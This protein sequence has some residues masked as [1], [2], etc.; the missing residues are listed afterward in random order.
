MPAVTRRATS[1]CPR[2]RF[3]ISL[4]SR[5]CVRP[6]SAMN[7]L[8]S[9]TILDDSNGL[10][11]NCTMPCPT[12]LAPMRTMLWLKPVTCMAALTTLNPRPDALMPCRSQDR[13][14]SPATCWPRAPVALSFD[15]SRSCFRNSGPRVSRTALANCVSLSRRFVEIS[16]SCHERSWI[17]SFT[18]L[19]A[20]SSV[21]RSGLSRTSLARA[22][23]N[24]RRV[25]AAV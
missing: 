6:R 25:V 9:A 24:D 5:N 19:N 20:A 12:Y 23:T 22:L 7:E 10:V 21:Y 1:V 14:A 4:I 16:H 17:T 15:Q 18:P 2:T 11:E 13:T 3:L 8:F